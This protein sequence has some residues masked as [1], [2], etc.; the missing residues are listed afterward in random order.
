MRRLDRQIQNIEDLYKVALDGEVLIMAFNNGDYPY[1]LPVNY[2]CKLENNNLYFLFH[3]A[4]E[5]T[6]YNFI[7]DDAKVSFEVDCNH[8]LIVKYDKGYCTMN[9]D[10][11][12]GKGTI[13]ELKDYDEIYEALNLLV[14]HHHTN[15]DF[16][17]NPA[18]I[19]RTRT[20]EI[21]VTYITGKSKK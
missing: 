5:G 11:I 9:Y 3:G 18:A 14:K 6:K 19:G 8:E 13:K 4:L 10:S 16:K 15:D 2:G 21:K 1:I 17:F 12:I 20:F 7:Y